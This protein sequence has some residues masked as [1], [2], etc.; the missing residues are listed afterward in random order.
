MMYDRL[1]RDRTATRAAKRKATP[2]EPGFVR[3]RASSERRRPATTTRVAIGVCVGE[4]PSTG[5]SGSASSRS[6][7]PNLDEAKLEVWYAVGVI[8]PAELR[9]YIPA[10]REDG[11]AP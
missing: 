3:S 10:C 5:C 6:G 9:L 11:P 2:L 1:G 4:R 8:E 7:T